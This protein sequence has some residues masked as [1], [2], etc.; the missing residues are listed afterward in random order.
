[1][2]YLSALVLLSMVLSV[3][4]QDLKTVDLRWKI[5]PNKPLTYGTTMKDISS[6]DMEMDFFSKLFESIKDSTSTDSSDQSDAKKTGIKEMMK[7]LQSAQQETDYICTLSN[8][9]KGV[10]DIVMSGRPE[11]DSITEDDDEDEEE[12]DE[13]K[14]ASSFIKSMQQGVV[15]R[16]SVTEEGDM[17]SFWLKSAQMNLIAIL[18]QLPSKPVS[19]GDKWGLNI[20]LISND[21]NF[22]CDSAYKINEVELIDIRIENNEHIAVLKY[23]IEEYVKGEFSMPS[24]MSSGNSTTPTTMRLT[25]NGTAEFSVEQGKWLNYNALMSYTATGFTSGTKKTQFSLKPE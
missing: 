8:K 17:H 23:N 4:G 19:V 15:L 10:I 13:M 14:K 3:N 1:M 21:Q 18:F 2:K 7:A 24:F 12:E 22:V 11:E 25:H 16:G 6:E 20:H 5:D 9:G